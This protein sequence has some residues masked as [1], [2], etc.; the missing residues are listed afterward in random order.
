MKPYWCNFLTETK[1]WTFTYWKFE[2]C[3]KSRSNR[4]WFVHE[5][6]LYFDGSFY[7]VQSSKIQYYNRTRERFCFESLIKDLFIDFLYTKERSFLEKNQ[8]D[9]A[10]ISDDLWLNFGKV[11]KYMQQKEK[12]M[13][14]LK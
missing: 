4:S 11:F 9:I 13:Q 1:N 6:V 8:D 5:W 2:F 3:C 14:E 12:I 7:P 10:K